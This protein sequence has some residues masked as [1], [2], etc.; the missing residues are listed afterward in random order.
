MTLLLK[1]GDYVPDSQGALSTLSG[2]GEVLQRVLLK[3]TARR[4]GFPLLP[5][6]GS[7]LYQLLRHSPAQREAQAKQYIQEAL[8]DET[9]LSITGVALTPMSE[10]ALHIAVTM[11]W[12]GETLTAELDVNQ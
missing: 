1:D 8:A 6:L 7:Q 9:D 12:Q 4:G 11:D 2:S 10:D 3:L 5:E